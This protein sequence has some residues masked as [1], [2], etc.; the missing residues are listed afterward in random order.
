MVFRVCAWCN[1][2]IGCVSRL[3]SIFKLPERVSHGI[4]RHC[5]EDQI[6]RLNENSND[7]YKNSSNPI[8][9]ELKKLA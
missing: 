2:P 6:S 8:T 4:C 3:V 9:G 1:R 5:K 7:D